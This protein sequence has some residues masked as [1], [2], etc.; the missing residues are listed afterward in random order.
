M[1]VRPPLAERMASVNSESSHADQTTRVGSTCGKER[2][3]FFVPVAE[4]PAL[5]AIY[6]RAADAT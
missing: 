6:K 3:A 4:G 1:I 2:F 5:Q